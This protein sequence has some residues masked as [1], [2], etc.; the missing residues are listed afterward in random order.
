MINLYRTAMIFIIRFPTVRFAA[1]IIH[2]QNK[3][4]AIVTGK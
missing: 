2:I 4:D 3:R 1:S